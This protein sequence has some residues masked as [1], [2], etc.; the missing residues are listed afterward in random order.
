MIQKQSKLKNL[1]LVDKYWV[2]VIVNL[3][4]TMMKQIK[5]N[6]IKIQMIMKKARVLMV[7]I[8]KISHQPR[9]GL[10]KIYK[11]GKREV[12]SVCIS[13]LIKTEMKYYV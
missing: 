3:L 4:N 8:L 5:I 6:I 10:L 7:M 1:M 9:I 2:E 13:F 11:I 12:K